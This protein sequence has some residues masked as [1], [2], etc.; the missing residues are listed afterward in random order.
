MP[1]RGEIRARAG[2]HGRLAVVAAAAIAALLAPASAPAAPKGPTKGNKPSKEK[3]QKQRDANRRQKRPNVIV[4]MTDDQAD[5]MAGLDRTVRLLGGR[6]T[7]FTNSY[8]SFPLC[9]PSR[10]TF[11][12]G[13][14]SHN[15]GVV[16]TEL[17][18]GYNGLNH[19]NTL[20]VWLRQAGYR[21]AMVGKYLNGYGISDGIAEPVPDAKE[22][23][24][25]WRDWYALT[26]NTDQKRINYKLNE[27]GKVRKYGKKPRDYVTDVLAKHAVEIVRDRAPRP[28]P[29]F[30]WFNPTAPHGENGNYSKNARNPS[31]ARRHLGLAGAALA[32]RTPNFNEED[33][34][35]KSGLVKNT[36]KLSSS[37]ILDIDDRH[38]GRIESLLSV[39]EAVKRIFARV[40]K[41]GDLSKTYFIFTSD[42][43]LQLG[44]HRLLLKNY[45]YEESVRVPL[46]I[47]GPRF[48]Q[49][50][51]RP[52]FVVNADLAPTIVD[53]TGVTPGLTMDGRSLLQFAGDAT[54]GLNRE[55]FFENTG[56]DVGIRSGKWV[57]FDRGPNDTDELYDMAADP[58]QLDNVLGGIPGHPTPDE[59]AAAAQ[60]QARV[61]QL[62]RCA[63]A[64]CP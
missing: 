19:T 10:A 32:P 24:P 49:G 28:K 52:G 25:G 8:V 37:E 59:T 5:S 56:D 21:T 27:N 3:L 62:R 17:P 30:L 36:P 22:I 53:V 57:Y 12:T 4:I 18:N 26:A 46:L 34:S 6:G 38:R 54:A 58:F 64:S 40:K 35:D 11:L 31:P 14:Y 60:L 51:V 39:D 55:V 45:L 9:C 61:A 44:S 47:R 7:T 43:G 41:A 16:S 33:V 15:H 42:N 20:A 13:Q 1:A 50:E 48:P 29:F 2:R 63:G 23:P